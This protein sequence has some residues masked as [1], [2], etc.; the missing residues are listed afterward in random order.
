V[1]FADL[2]AWGEAL[3]WETLDLET[4][5]RFF[6]RF[7]VGKDAMGSGDPGESFFALSQ[8]LVTRDS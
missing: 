1:N 3:G 4:Q 8:R 6:E 2:T 5:A 7:G